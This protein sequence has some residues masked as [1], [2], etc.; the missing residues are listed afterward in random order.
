MNKIINI[1]PRDRSEIEA[2]ACAWLVR[3]DDS[4]DESELKE[5]RQWLDRSPL[6]REAFA[7]AAGTW[8]ELNGL[9]Q[10]LEL[11]ASTIARQRPS[12]LRYSLA[13]AAIV[14]TAGLVAWLSAPLRP[15]QEPYRA[16]HAT[17]I[18]EVRTVSLPDG[19][20]AQ[21]NTGTR[22]AFTMDRN[23][24]LARLDEGEAWFDIARDPERPFV[25]YASRLAVRAVGT[26]F[27]V[28]V[29]GNR[30]D[31]TVTEGRVEIAS[32][33]AA[34]AESAELELR[35]FDD[36]TESRVALDAG[37]HVVYDGRIEQVSRWAAPQIERSLSW[38]DGMLIFDNDSL[39]HVVA[40][41]GRYT[42]QKIVISDS[43]LRDLRFGGYFRVGDIASI[44][45]TFEEDF[46]IRVE[47]I[48]DELVYLSQRRH[49]D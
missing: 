34:L 41:I 47:R 21:L 32:M 6:H 13:A 19:T 24:R 14:L 25:V 44:L 23:A 2:E 40:E 8:G 30:V 11:D 12:R 17:A 45:A 1:P 46:D 29:Q 43:D 33:H 7:R 39:A 37:Q 36:D 38:R 48:N 22:I 26:A 5:L 16:E 3:L 18:G 35:R 10:W 9:G 49:G 42:P 28:R 20:A 4:R 31:L 15:A 27:S